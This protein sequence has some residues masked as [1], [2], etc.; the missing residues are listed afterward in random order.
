MIWRWLASSTHVTTLSQDDRLGE[1]S[2]FIPVC[3][4]N[5]IHNVYMYTATCMCSLFCV[6]KA[7]HF[8]GAATYTLCEFGA[9]N[10]TIWIRTQIVSVAWCAWF[11][12]AR[13][14]GHKIGGATWNWATIIVNITI[15]FTKQALTIHHFG[16]PSSTLWLPWKVLR[17]GQPSY[18]ML[19]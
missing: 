14:A 17:S 2:L 12:C 9:E 4:V 8:Y 5:C 1:S 13:Y 3:S 6:S 7:S 18:C 16:M 19:F 15:G 10:F 11:A